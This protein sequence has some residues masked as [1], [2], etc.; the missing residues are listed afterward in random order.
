MA[1]LHAP[2]FFRISRSLS[3]RELSNE[4]ERKL[5]GNKC[6]TPALYA[7]PGNIAFWPKPAIGFF[8]GIMYPAW[9]S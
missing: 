8:S 6:S 9:C 4:K 1:A 2:P 5:N 3:R 7:K